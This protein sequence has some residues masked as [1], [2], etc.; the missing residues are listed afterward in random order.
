M[1]RE[2]RVKRLRLLKITNEVVFTDADGLKSETKLVEI[3]NK[4]GL[5]LPRIV[6][7]KK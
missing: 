1:G 6:I 7:P 4:L 3:A 5:L 2:N